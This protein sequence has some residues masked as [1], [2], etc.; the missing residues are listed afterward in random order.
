MKARV[1]GSKTLKAKL[2]ELAERRVV[3]EDGM[4]LFSEDEEQRRKRLREVEI[5]LQEVAD[6]VVEGMICKFESKRF[7]RVLPFPSPIDRVL[8][9]I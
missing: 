1:L 7:I 6:G 8:F 4:G 3:V 9:S 2:Q 5:Q